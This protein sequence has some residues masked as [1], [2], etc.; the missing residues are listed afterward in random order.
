M[1]FGYVGALPDAEPTGTAVWV[2][3]G[4]KTKKGP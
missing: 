1:M 3:F 2:Q 4:Y